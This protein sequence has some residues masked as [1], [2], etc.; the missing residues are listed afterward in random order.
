MKKLGILII[1]LA[2]GFSIYY[3]FNTGTLPAESNSAPPPPAEPAELLDDTDTAEVTIEHG[4]TVLTIVERLH[5]GPVP[6]P[7]EQVSE[8]FK[9]LNGGTAPEK[10][11]VDESYLFPLYN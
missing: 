2:V 9:T 8:D 3:D 6:V 5:D 7:I 11:K 4:Q 10:I 1:V